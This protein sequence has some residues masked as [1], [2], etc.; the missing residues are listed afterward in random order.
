[1][2]THLVGFCH[3]SRE[4]HQNDRTSLSVFL[5]R[6][7]GEE[8]QTWGNR[9]QSISKTSPDWRDIGR[10]LYF[11]LPKALLKLK[12]LP[13]LQTLIYL[14]L[15]LFILPLWFWLISL[16]LR[17]LKLVALRRCTADHC[18]KPW[19]LYCVPSPLLRHLTTGLTC[20]SVDPYP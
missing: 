13:L 18:L 9:F 11:F 7:D 8:K 14:F 6:C 20:L 19:I 15:Y 1:M 2:T 16:S 3:V 5:V 4:T 17:F 12:L 10:R